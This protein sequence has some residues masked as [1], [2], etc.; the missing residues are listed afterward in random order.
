MDALISIVRLSNGTLSLD[1]Y[2]ADDVFSRVKDRNDAAEDFR[3]I[4]AR[5][6]EEDIQRLEIKDD[7]LFRL[8]MCK[9]EAF[10][11]IAQ[12]V[13]RTLVQFACFSD[14]I[15]TKSIRFTQIL[16]QCQNLQQLEGELAFASKTDYEDFVDALS[17]A[18]DR[19]IS[20]RLEL[21]LHDSE[22]QGQLPLDTLLA[23]ISGMSQLQ[24][25]TL[26]S[27]VTPC[28]INPTHILSTLPSLLPNL[29]KMEIRYLFKDEHVDPL[30]SALEQRD[31][32][33]Q[34]RV[35]HQSNKPNVRLQKAGI[36]ALIS[37]VQRHAHISIST[38][39]VKIYD[40]NPLDQ[41]CRRLNLTSH[42]NEIGRGTLL[43]SNASREA[44]IGVILRAAESQTLDIIWKVILIRPDVLTM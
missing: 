35:Y 15:F 24:S 12:A 23:C 22:D 19:L 1:K 43:Q 42:L 39:P 31:G 29:E 5:L 28:G 37:L 40:R 17:T 10:D 16:H 11:L 27:A 33:I 13:N 9:T 21:N 25:L 26:T 7:F 38:C 2:F 32:P 20:L 8:P 34:I 36:D 4:M 18:A 6:Q 3:R 14:I 41:S 30:C 44:C